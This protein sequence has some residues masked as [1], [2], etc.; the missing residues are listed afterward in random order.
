MLSVYTHTAN[1]V[2]I[3]IHYSKILIK[4]NLFVGLSRQQTYFRGFPVLKFS[5]QFEANIINISDLPIKE[6]GTAK[7]LS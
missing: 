7:C 4:P 2:F 6:L 5:Q 3:Q 1:I